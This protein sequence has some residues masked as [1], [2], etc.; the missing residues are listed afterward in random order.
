M[1]LVKHSD[2]Y[3]SWRHWTLSKSRTKLR[4][5]FPRIEMT[6]KTH[7]WLS[8]YSL[9]HLHVINVKNDVYKN[10][11]RRRSCTS[12]T[13][14]IH[15]FVRFVMYC[16]ITTLPVAFYWAWIGK[17]PWQHWKHTEYLLFFYCVIFIHKLDII[18]K[19]MCDLFAN[20]LSCNTTKYYS[21][22]STLYRV[23]AKI[24]RCSAIAERPRCRV[25][26][27]FRQK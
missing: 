26:Y 3:R 5:S 20:F 25:R 23:I 8:L 2:F 18:R 14:K 17:M 4:I 16:V 6:W 13:A 9:L 1:I 21:D 15:R 7:W 22:R 12:K 10:G 27:S 11:Y 24:T 19:N